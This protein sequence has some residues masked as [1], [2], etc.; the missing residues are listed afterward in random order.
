MKQTTAVERIT[1]SIKHVKTLLEMDYNNGVQWSMR[2][3]YKNI[4]E[5]LSIAEEQKELERQQIIDAA[6]SIDEY[7]NSRPDRL[8]FGEQYYTEKFSK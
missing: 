1:E 8:S 5:I 6:N 3:M 4:N 2:I 7:P